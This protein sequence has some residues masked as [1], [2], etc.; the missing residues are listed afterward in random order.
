MTAE[1]PPQQDMDW[2]ALIDTALTMPGNVGNTYSRFHNYS[3]GNIVLLYSQGI[4]PQPVATYKRWQELGRQVVKGAKAK[5]I[6]RPITVKLK[7]KLDEEGNP[8]TLTKF[9]PVRC[10]FPLDETTGDELPPADEFP[11]WSLAQAMN[12]LN[13]TE[14]PFA[15][16]DG[17]VAGY[18]FGRNLAVSR[19]AV[20]PIKTYT[21][22]MAHIEAGHTAK[23]APMDYQ[24][25]RGVYEFEAEGSAYLVCNEIGQQTDAQATE[26]RGYIQGWLRGDRPA[27][28]S[29]RRVF[30]TTSSILAAG[31]LAVESAELA[32]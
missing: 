13:I 25:H 27:D 31:R 24:Q 14:V 9:K 21:H 26:S 28:E 30:K 29:I 22:E 32:S 6:I 3:W 7:D 10:I 17:N 20:N 23:L 2:A 15:D 1:R 8:K 11:G 5:E 4:E 19:V 18:S 12:N 16:Y